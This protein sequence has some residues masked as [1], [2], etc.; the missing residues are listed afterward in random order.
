MTDPTRQTGMGLWSDAKS[1]IE[2]ASI[3]QA[4][5]KF[6]ISSA[7]Y[8]LAGHGLEEVLKAYLLSRGASHR[9]LKA[10]GHDLELAVEAAILAGLE[11]L[12][13]LSVEERDLVGLLNVEYKAKELEYRVTGSKHRPPLDRLITLGAEL[14]GATRAV[15]RATVP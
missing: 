1:L 13:P 7:A 9:M 15:C 3:L 4:H 10:I 5:P 11:S 14:C 12:R 8:W 6:E 2:A